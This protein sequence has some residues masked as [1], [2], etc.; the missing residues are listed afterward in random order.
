[1]RQ[2]LA[3]AAFL[4]LALYGCGSDSSSSTPSDGVPADG[5]KAEAV[6][7]AAPEQ[8]NVLLVIWDT[9][10][11]DHLSLYG[12]DRPTTPNLEKIAADST[13][14]E[15]AVPGG[16]WTAPS[17]AS[18]FSGM[19]THNHK[20]DFH[21]DDEEKSL[22]LPDSVVTLAE[23]MKDRGYRTG[24]YINKKLIDAN[25]TY[26][27]GFD[28]WEWTDPEKIGPDALSF[29][30]SAGDDPWFVIAYYSG[31]HAPYLPGEGFNKWADTSMPEMNIRG[32]HD[33]KEYPKHWVCWKDIDRG[34]L[35]LTEQQ[36]DYLKALYDGA[37]L[38]HDH[39]LGEF[40]KGMNEKGFADDTLFA[41]T[42]D[43]G[44]A[45]NDHETE[46][47]WH[48][49]PFENN[50]LVPLVVRLPGELPTK[51]VSTAVRNMDLY[52]TL[53]ELSGGEVKHTINAENLMPVIEGKEGDRFNIGFTNA[54]AAHTWYR[55][56]EYKLIYSRSK[57][58]K[59][60]PHLLEVY[61]LKADP[62]EQNNL[63]KARPELVAQLKSERQA[64]EDATALNIAAGTKV[65][66]EQNELLRELGYIT[67]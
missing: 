20:V 12:Y 60:K 39:L 9:T 62:D 24:M 63:G 3:L 17:I 10:R 29:M 33:E 66:D 65:T 23:V 45:F 15:Q 11:A 42:S 22:N 44:E 5:V 58:T 30:E 48:T 46:R 28:V 2:N 52:P 31:P 27:Q 55:T 8:R 34:K 50:Q 67:D 59:T 26:H 16:Y 19:Y 32:C 41:F 1:M 47:S 25:P 43:H 56:P 40:W 37:I 4:P 35:T 54:G 14:F 49:R 7:E 57:P 64:I 61:D 21:I 18:L 51:R 13:V 36:W 6:K 53:I 38:W